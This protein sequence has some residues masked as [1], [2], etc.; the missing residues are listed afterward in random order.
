MIDLFSGTPGSGKS[1]HTADRIKWALRMKHPV[2]CNF[3]IRHDVKGYNYF[4]YCPNEKLKPAFLI[5][6]SRNYFKGERIKEDAILL[7]IDE[8]QLLFNA[9]EWNTV[10]RNQWLSFY[11]QHRKY[12]YHI[13]LVAQFDRMIDRQIRSLIEYNYIHRKLANM[14]LKGILVDLAMGG[15]TFVAVKVWY[16]MNEKVGQ[17]F[18]HARKKLYSIYDTYNSFDAENVVQDRGAAQVTSVRQPV[19][20]TVSVPNKNTP[21]NTSDDA[22]V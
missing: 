18:F 15:R 6:F 19:S 5:D 17:T 4:T 20:V 21:E 10:G 3:D 11:T 2:I 14:G 22:R 13:V 1:L 8:C 9:R 7:F 16:P 12:G